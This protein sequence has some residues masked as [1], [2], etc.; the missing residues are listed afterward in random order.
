MLY[1]SLDQRIEALRDRL[2][3]VSAFIHVHPELNFTETQAAARLVSELRHAGFE[4]QEGAG[5]LAT[6]FVATKG[7]GRI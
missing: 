1:E 3:S 4:V 7:A 2:W 6:S 5:G